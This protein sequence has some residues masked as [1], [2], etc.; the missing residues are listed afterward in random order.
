MQIILQDLSITTYIYNQYTKYD[1]N[2]VTIKDNTFDFEE[3]EEVEK[4]I[5]FLREWQC[6][7]FKKPTTEKV[8]SEFT[9]WHSE[10]CGSLP[11]KTKSLLKISDH[12]LIAY[13]PIF[14]ALMNCHASYREF[15]KTGKISPATFGPVGA[16]KA[17]FAMRK[18]AFAPWDNPIIDKLNKL[19]SYPDAFISKDGIGYSH[20]MIFIKRQLLLLESE[21]D[22]IMKLPQIL[23]RPH[24]SLPKI[25]DEHLWVS[26]TGGID[27]KELLNRALK[28]KS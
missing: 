5:Q 7:Q 27:P 6:R 10:Y 20:Y 17:L 15:K 11:P 24:S 14:Q 3:S 26:L 4:L 23:K 25:I 28:F 13:A 2:Y 18:N 9:T 19:G 8:F 12:Q 22:D 21:V 1:Q 16:A